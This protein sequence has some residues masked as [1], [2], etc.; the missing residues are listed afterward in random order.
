MTRT[1]VFA[2]GRVNLIGD[3]TDYVGGLA[4]PMA[5]HLGTTIVFDRS[6]GRIDLDSDHHGRVELTANNGIFAPSSA[7]KPTWSRFVIAAIELLK[8]SPE[9]GI[10]GTVTTTLPIAAGLSSSA[11]LEIALCLALGSEASGIRLAGI[12]RDLE[13]AATGVPCGMLDQIAIATAQAG[14]ATLIDFATLSVEPIELPPEVLIQIVNSGPRQLE[15]S[16]YAS[17]RRQCEEAENEIGPLRKATMDDLS[18]LTN[19]MVKRR[20]KHVITENQRVLEFIDALG[21]HDL[22]A[23]GAAMLASHKSLKDDFEV[24]TPALD[25]LVETACNTKGVYGA[26]LT[27][28]GFGGCMVA[29]TEPGVELRNAIQIESAQGPTKRMI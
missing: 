2:P 16:A 1:Q 23:A 12:A 8:V 9:N 27:G 3:H 7:L 28:A 20:A 19:Q 29:L 25:Q 10:V 18:G 5:I 4:L 26:R 15:N 21:S 24:S 22:R 6:P 11:S 13:E 17:R 14:K